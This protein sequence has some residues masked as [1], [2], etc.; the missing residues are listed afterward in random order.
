MRIL[1]KPVEGGGYRSKKSAKGVWGVERWDTRKN[2]DEEYG[3][4]VS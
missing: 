3:G 4:L 1:S 2:N